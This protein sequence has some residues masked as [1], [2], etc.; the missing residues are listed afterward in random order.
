MTIRELISKLSECDDDI[1]DYEAGIILTVQLQS[2]VRLNARAI[3]NSVQ[4]NADIDAK[5]LWLKARTE[6][7]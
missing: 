7:K 3:I 4:N 5:I 1:L 2:Q 6:S